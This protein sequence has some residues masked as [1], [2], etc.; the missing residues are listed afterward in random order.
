M[1]TDVAKP[2]S[3]VIL[4]TPVCGQ[5]DEQTDTASPICV[6]FMQLVQR[7]HNK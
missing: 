1:R 7:T 5:T 6:P 3:Q 2:L 4:A